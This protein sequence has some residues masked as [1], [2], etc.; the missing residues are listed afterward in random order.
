VL[1]TGGAAA[2]MG[3]LLMLNFRA[4]AAARPPFA[5]DASRTATRPEPPAGPPVRARA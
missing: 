3:L 4:R 5:A 1:H 2:L